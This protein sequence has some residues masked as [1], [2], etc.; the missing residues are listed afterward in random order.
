MKGK[1][2]TK[3]EIVNL[4]EQIILSDPVNQENYRVVTQKLMRF[5]NKD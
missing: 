4:Y 5:L 2:T 3:Q 1:Q